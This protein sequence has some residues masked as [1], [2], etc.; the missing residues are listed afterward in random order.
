L[1]ALASRPRVVLH[2]SINIS[3]QNLTGPFLNAYVPYALKQKPREEYCTSS[4]PFGQSSLKS[5]RQISSSGL[6]IQPAYRH[7]SVD[8][9]P[10]GS[11]D[12]QKLGSAGI[13]LKDSA[14]V[15]EPIIP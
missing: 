8:A 1:L 9:W 2:I 6:I 11:D 10:E 13:G 4:D 5:K 15:P 12:V 14:Q 7:A 3:G